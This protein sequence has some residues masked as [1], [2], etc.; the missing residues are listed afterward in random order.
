MKATEF[1]KVQKVSCA[2]I[3]ITTFLSDDRS[4]IMVSA[5]DINEW[6]NLE[7]DLA[8]YGLEEYEVYTL[9]D[10][11]ETHY[12]VPQDLVNDFLYYFDTKSENS[13]NDLIDFRHYF[14]CEVVSF[15]NRFAPSSASLSM[16]DAFVIVDHCNKDLRDVTG[17]PDGMVYEFLVEKLGYNRIPL[18]SDLPTLELG[19]VSYWEMLITSKIEDNIKMGMDIDSA[20]K[21]AADELMGPAS[22]IG[23]VTRTLT[24]DIH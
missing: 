17:T 8:G 6:L 15:W 9:G 13:V 2:G 21:D 24:A 11:Q 1:R 12:C 5:S 18:R 14:M 7:A 10:S 19:F 23:Y 20:M 3:S 22:N 4:V 16:R